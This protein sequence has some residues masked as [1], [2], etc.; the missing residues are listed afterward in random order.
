MVHRRVLSL[1]IVLYATAPPAHTP[2]KSGAITLLPPYETA[3][4]KAGS[5]ADIR[6]K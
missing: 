2:P 5:L 1:A 3:T 6:L 4:P